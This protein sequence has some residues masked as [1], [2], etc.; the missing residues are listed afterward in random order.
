MSEEEL[1]LNQ[2]Q[3]RELKIG[4]Q[5]WIDLLDKYDALFV[6][7]AESTVNMVDNARKEYH[8]PKNADVMA[9]LKLMEL[10]HGKRIAPTDKDD[11]PIKCE[12]GSLV[13]KL[14]EE[15]PCLSCGKLHAE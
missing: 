2:E 8:V 9:A 10:R 3:Y 13:V 4:L 14:R 15:T 7:E 12:C 1:V 11:G 6:D 5:E